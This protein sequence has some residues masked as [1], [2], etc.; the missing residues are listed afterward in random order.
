MISDSN[1]IFKI[2][3]KFQMQVHNKPQSS[4]LKNYAYVKDFSPYCLGARVNKLQDTECKKGKCDLPKG[5][6]RWY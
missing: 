4:Q 2:D 3:E 5:R 6:G 1:K